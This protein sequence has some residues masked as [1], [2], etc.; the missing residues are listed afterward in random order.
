[1]PSSRTPQRLVHTLAATVRRTYAGHRIRAAT[2][3]AGSGTTPG[4]RRFPSPHMTSG[5]RALRPGG[6]RGQAR[7]TSACRFS[8]QRPRSGCCGL[9][10]A[11]A[12]RSRIRRPRGHRSRRRAARRR[13]LGVSAALWPWEAPRGARRAPARK[14]PPDQYVHSSR[15]PAAC[16]CWYFAAVPYRSSRRQVGAFHDADARSVENQRAS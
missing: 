3:H 16:Y 8:S 7:P 15:R 12:A 5:A 4:W 14:A 13:W 6:C 10:H 9:P 11:S 2:R 1:M